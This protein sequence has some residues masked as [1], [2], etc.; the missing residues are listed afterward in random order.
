MENKTKGAIIHSKC[1]YAELGEKNTNYFLS[2]EKRNFNK[3]V[4]NKLLLDKGK[5]ICKEKEILEALKKIYEK[6]YESDEQLALVEHT[7][8]DPFLTI[9]LNLAQNIRF[10]AKMI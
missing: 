1:R 2:M 6:L 4:I 10:Y 7:K 8:I 9:Y 3:K 5:E